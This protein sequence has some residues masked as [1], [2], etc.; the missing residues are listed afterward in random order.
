MKYDKAG[1]PDGWAKNAEGQVVMTR[2]DEETLKALAKVTRGE[3][4]HV[5]AE[6]FGL[7]EVR[8]KMAGLAAAQREDKV[9]IEREES[10]PFVIFPA[11]LL[12]CGALMISDR[13]PPTPS[14]TE[15]S[16]QEV[17]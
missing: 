12:L 7:D 10:F 14:Q 16:R 1:E 17:A 6:S 11:F 9:Q 2:L 5:K 13:R 8:E 3:Y 4:I 15:R